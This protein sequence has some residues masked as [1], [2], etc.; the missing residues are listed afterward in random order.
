MKQEKLFPNT[1]ADLGLGESALIDSFT[2][3]EI[4]MKLLEMGCL[5]GEV[6]QVKNIAPFG[7][8]IAISVGGY[9]LGLRKSEAS[10]VIIRPVPLP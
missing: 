2:D 5:P 1:L 9:V 10:S 4:S 7:D 8:P 6:I 3:K